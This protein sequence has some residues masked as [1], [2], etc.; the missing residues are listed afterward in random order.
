[1]IAFWIDA[2]LNVEMKDE[3]HEIARKLVEIQHNKSQ[4]SGYSN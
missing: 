3:A 2:A 4:L 1:M